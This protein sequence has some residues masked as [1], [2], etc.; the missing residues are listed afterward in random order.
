M[1]Y[2]TGDA[3]GPV[4]LGYRSLDGISQRLGKENLRSKN[5]PEFASDDFVIICENQK[6]RSTGLTG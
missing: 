2:I 1:I 5:L 3:H 4:R 6:R